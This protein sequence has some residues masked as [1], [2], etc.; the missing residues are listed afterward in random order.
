MMF[1]QKFQI[2][3]EN[4]NHYLGNKVIFN[5]L[6]KEEKPITENDTNISIILISIFCFF[7]VYIIPKVAELIP[8]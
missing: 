4:I 3:K 1:F 5:L 8:K 2:L 7:E 6:D